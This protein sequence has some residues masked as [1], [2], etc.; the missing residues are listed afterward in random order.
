MPLGSFAPAEGSGRAD[1]SGGLSR[2]LHPTAARSCAQERGWM[3]SCAARPRGSPCP[4][5]AA[6]PTAA[7][8]PLP[9]PF[10]SFNPAWPRQNLPPTPSEVTPPPTPTATLCPP[11]PAPPRAQHSPGGHL[12]LAAATP[13]SCSGPRRPLGCTSTR[14]L[15][16]PARTL[17]A[18][19]VLIETVFGGFSVTAAKQGAD[20]C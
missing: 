15:P 3:R 12:Q 16:A 20:T 17:R 9:T 2:P 11:P 14:R 10:V 7:R 6:R 4:G 8:R 5:E 1:S 19:A 13:T 18:R